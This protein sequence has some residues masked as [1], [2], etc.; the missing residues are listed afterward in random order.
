LAPY[1]RLDGS[2]GRPKLGDQTR[3]A[4]RDVLAKAVPESFRIDRRVGAIGISH[5]PA[6]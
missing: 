6:R 2:D 3:I 5:A 4:H 1:D